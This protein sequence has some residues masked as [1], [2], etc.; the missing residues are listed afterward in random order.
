[1]KM[2]ACG[3][4]LLGL[5]WVGGEG[6]RAQTV[7]LGIARAGGHLVLSWPATIT[8]GVLQ[9][10]TNL[11]APNWVALSN[12]VTGTVSNSVAVTN[13]ALAGFFRLH[14]S[15][16]ST[17]SSSGKGPSGAVTSGMA[18]IPAGTFTIGDTLDGATDAIPTSV[19]VSG[20]YLDTNLVSYGQWQT[21]YGYAATNGYYF[22]Q[23]TSNGLYVADGKGTNYPVE[24]VDWYDCV[25]WCN[26]R[27][28]QAG[29]APVYYTDAGFTQVFT[30]GDSGTTVYANWATNGY[31][32]PTE[33]E[34]EKAA[35]GGL[36]GQRFPWGDTISWSQA[37]YF[38]EPEEFAYDLA[39]AF[40]Y[41]PVFDIGNSP[42]T[43]PV[44]YFAPNGYGLTDMAGNLE[45]WCWDWYAGPPYPAGSP[46]LGGTDPQG[47]VGPLYNRA[48]RGGPWFAPA[49]Y[50]RSAFRFSDNPAY[51]V[52]VIG[53]RCVLSAGQ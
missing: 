13:T 5:L 24:T 42:Y 34:W 31:R 27:S 3:W 47:P 19:T 41:D 36:S 17:S 26:A 8:N 18:L 53:F 51:A 50:A 11:A 48:L 49:N 10:A 29:L 16:N 14:L 37:N 1:M 9:S 35:R 40:G 6:A 33:A 15:T 21:V 2:K 12:V 38:G 32:L 4:I 44:G 39:P 25:K 30:N 23:S 45:E 43:S 20:F 46:Y 7:H 28:A 22:Y 52:N